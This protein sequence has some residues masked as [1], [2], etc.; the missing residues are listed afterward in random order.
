MI[1]IE[2]FKMMVDYRNS[3]GLREGLK[4]GLGEWNVKSG[5]AARFGFNMSC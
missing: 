5:Y 4:S 3:L 2:P 1:H